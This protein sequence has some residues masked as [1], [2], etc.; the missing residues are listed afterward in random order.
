[1]NRICAVACSGTTQSLRVNLSL[2]SKMCSR[3]SVPQSSRGSWAQPWVQRCSP[4]GHR[5]MWIQ[6]S[7]SLFCFQVIG[8]Y[9]SHAPCIFSYRYFFLLQQRQFPYPLHSDTQRQCFCPESKGFLNAL[10]C[11]LKSL[12]QCFASWASHHILSCDEGT[13]KAAS[14]YTSAMGRWH[15][16]TSQEG[17]TPMQ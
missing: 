15:L 7:V 13:W 16:A 8:L 5:A 6:V 10:Q 12:V 11:H 4:H 9:Y 17:F 1:M 3:E 2:R 14:F